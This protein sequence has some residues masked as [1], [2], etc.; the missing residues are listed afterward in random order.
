MSA[1]TLCAPSMSDGAIKMRIVKSLLRKFR[2]LAGRN[3]SKRRSSAPARLLGLT[4]ILTLTRL[5]VLPLLWAH[6]AAS[7]QGAP[8][9]SGARLLGLRLLGRHAPG[10]SG[11]SAPLALPQPRTSGVPHEPSA[12]V[13]GAPPHASR[14]PRSTWRLRAA[15]SV[16][17][18][19]PRR[20][21]VHRDPGKCLGSASAARASLQVS[22][23]GHSSSAASWP[24][25]W[26]GLCQLLRIPLVRPPTGPNP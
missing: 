9:G 12:G 2:G 10:S 20:R 15:A 8:P 4:L 23:Q 5:L 11:R 21:S 7:H 16:L 17:P 6:L 18:R 26:Q 19:G 25:R 3:A 1:V 14:A 22:L 13:T 24:C